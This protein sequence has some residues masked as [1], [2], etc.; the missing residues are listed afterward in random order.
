MVR[1][2]QWTGFEAAALQEAMRRSVRDF[3]LLLGVETTTVVNWRTGLSAVRPRSNTQAML[4][5]TLDQRA[6]VDDRARFEQILSQGEAAWRE[7][8]PVTPRREAK[9]AQGTG[10]LQTSAARSGGTLAASSSSRKTRTTVDR[11]HPAGHGGD[12]PT[13]ITDMNRRELLRLLSIATTALPALGAVDWD[14]VHFAAASGRVDTT[15]LDQYGRLN[16]M[17][18]KSYGEAETKAAV[19]VAAREH[20]A[21]LIESLRSCRSAELRRRQLELI[22]NALQLTGEILFDSSHFA[23]AAHCYALSGTFAATARA[24]DLWACA[25]TRH[26]YVGVIDNRFRDALPLVDEAAGVARRGD[27]LLPTRYWVES[28]RAQVEAGLG[29]ASECERWF[30]AAR[31]VLGLEETPP[32]GWLRFSGERIDEEKASCLIRLR[33]PEPAERILTPLLDRPLSTR[34]RASVLVDLAAAGALRGDPIQAV[35]YGGT[36]VDIA[37]RTRSGY[38]ERRLTQLQPHLA[39]MRGDRHVAHLEHRITTLTTSTAH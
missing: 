38:L 1:G 15:I 23:E 27:G 12:Y 25:L 10:L 14:R 16:Q 4:D 39:R 3:A 17:L 29:N 18:W 22:A 26:A 28:V 7:R 11:G 30:D 36:A 20:L 21:L 13:E 24:F 5:T 37:R 2:W 9:G 32:L 33:Q 8:H 6:T 34:R 35:W 31:G 19:F